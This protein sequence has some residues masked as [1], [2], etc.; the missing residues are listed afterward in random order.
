MYAACLA[1]S[2]VFFST[3]V[4]AGGNCAVEG[5]E[6]ARELNFNTRRGGERA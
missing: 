5:N 4:V 1:E 2:G 6:R 3:G